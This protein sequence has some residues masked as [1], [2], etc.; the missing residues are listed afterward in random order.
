MGCKISNDAF[1]WCPQ[2]GTI[3]A[4]DCDHVAPRDAYNIKSAP[5]LLE[6]LESV[7]KWG[8]LPGAMHES[9]R[10]LVSKA[11]GETP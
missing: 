10:R 3:K 7:L 1:F 8:R 6:E 11:K 4:C 2:C 9:I 5:E